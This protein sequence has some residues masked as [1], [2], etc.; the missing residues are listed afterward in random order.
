MP[1]LFVAT[2][3]RTFLR[4][5]VRRAMFI[6]KIRS[7]AARY[8][9]FLAVQ[10]RR[11]K[12]WFTNFFTDCFEKYLVKRFHWRSEMSE[13]REHLR[14]SLVDLSVESWRFAKVFERMAASFEEPEKGRHVARLRWFLKRTEE[15]LDASGLR[16]VNVEGHPFDPGV[17]ATPLNIEEFGPEDGLEVE[18]MLEPII[19]SGER[20]VR[21]G[22]VLLRRA[23]L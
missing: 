13:E 1:N 19:M 16:I 21:T 15:V 9:S 5:G 22:T 20:L 14:S 23:K 2:Q 7:I 10:L 4:R 11:C 3:K 8:L 12:K 18:Q 17:A 6:E